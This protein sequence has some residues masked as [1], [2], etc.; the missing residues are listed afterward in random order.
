MVQGRI[1]DIGSHDELVVKSGTYQR[2]YNLQFA[3]APHA[4]VMVEE[5]L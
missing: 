3:D 2:L 1:T 5:A 4:E